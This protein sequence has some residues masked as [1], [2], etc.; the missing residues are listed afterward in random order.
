MTPGLSCT[1]LD[2]ELNTKVEENFPRFPTVLYTPSNSQRFR[3]NDFW[4]MTGFA[5][6]WDSGQIAATTRKWNMGLFGWDSSPKLNTKKLDNSP[7]FPLVNYIA[8][9]EQ[10]FTCYGILCINET[11]ETVW[12]RAAVGRYKIPE[13]KLIQNSGNSEYQSDRWLSQL[14]DGLCHDSK[15]SATSVSVTDMG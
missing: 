5:G 8:W 10:R 9:S 13:T 1:K 4:M 11:A 14:P 7:S 2:P 3:H 15:W 6:N 12:D